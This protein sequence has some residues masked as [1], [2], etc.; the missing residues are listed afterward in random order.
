LKTRNASNEKKTKMQWRRKSYPPYSL[1]QL[2]LDVS[3]ILISETNSLHNNPDSEEEVT[4][5]RG[6]PS[7]PSDVAPVGTSD[8]AMISSFL[9]LETEDANKVV[10]EER[11]ADLG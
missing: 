8:M 10:K 9:R 5:Q 4:K 7:N 1:I 11:I 2:S 6:P 3:S